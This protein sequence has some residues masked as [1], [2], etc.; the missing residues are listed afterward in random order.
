MK[1]TKYT[2]NLNKKIEIYSS[3]IKDK[4]LLRH[5]KNK[6]KK[7]VGGNNYNTN[8]KGQMSLFDSFIDDKKFNDFINREFLRE[9]LYITGIHPEAFDNFQLVIHNAWGN[10]L[11]K[12]DY[13]KAHEHGACQYSTC[14]Y[15]SKGE[16]FKTEIGDFEIEEGLLLTVP[17]YLAHWVNPI[18]EK[19][20]ISMVWNWNILNRDYKTTAHAQEVVLT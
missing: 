19:E 11:N 5:F 7:D 4:S 9:M 12:N 17:G 6:I 13:V 10:I 2:Y 16:S 15:F 18:K 20:R 3:Y 1:A 14:L 8:V